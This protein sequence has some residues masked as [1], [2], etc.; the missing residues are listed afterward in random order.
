LTGKR[1][2][3]VGFFRFVVLLIVFF[4]FFSIVFVL[5]ASGAIPVFDWSC[6]LR[7]VELA[8]RDDDDDDEANYA[9][10]MGKN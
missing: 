2:V 3:P 5:L 8:A 4:F 1:L 9:E 6:G 10:R 7:L